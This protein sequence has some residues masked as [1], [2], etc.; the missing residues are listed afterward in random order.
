MTLEEL[1]LWVADQFDQ[2]L[3]A[4]GVERGW[5]DMFEEDFEWRLERTDDHLSMINVWLPQTCAEV[6]GQLD[7]WLINYS[8][9]DSFTAATHVREHW[10]AEGWIV[11]DVMSN[12]GP[13]EM[14][15]RADRDDG[16]LLGLTAYPGQM[17]IEVVTPCS[18]HATVSDWRSHRPKPEST[19]KPKAAGEESDAS[20]PSS[21][22][23]SAPLPDEDAS[24]DLGAD[25]RK[26]AVL[27]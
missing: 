8:V 15:F 4:S 18:V 20:D 2:V 19:K 5:M 23:S 24:D 1:Q 7:E 17:S 26:E 13:D 21:P 22:N 14:R 11:S 16:A 25:A 27:E 10:E 3:R 6:G 9:E 12:P